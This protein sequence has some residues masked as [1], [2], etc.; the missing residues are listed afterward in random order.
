[1]DCFGQELSQLSFTNEELAKCR[2]WLKA[3]SLA[4]NLIV[5]L[6]DVKGVG[7]H[8][9][10][11]LQKEGFSCQY[12]PAILT[13]RERRHSVHHDK[14][15][16]L[17]A[18][19]VGKVILTKSEETLPVSAI[20]AQE[21]GYIRELDLLLQERQELVREQTAL[22]NQLHVL[23]HQY[24]GNTYRQ[25][26]KQ[27]FSEKALQWYQQDMDKGENKALGASISRR[28]K[29]LIL[30]ASQI[31][32]ITKTINVTDK[33]IPEVS[34]LKEKLIGC[35]TL[36]AAKIIVEIGTIMRFRSKATLAKYAGIA[37]VKNQSSNTN[38]LYTNTGGNRKL[39]QAIHT[40]A[41]SQIGGSGHEDAK[42]Y[43]Q[44]KLKEGKSKLWAI[45]CL[46][47]HICNK[48]FVLLKNESDKQRV[49]N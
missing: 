25:T 38:R 32:D 30:T 15:D 2:D 27:I 41:L 3:L 13:Q 46:K 5:G 22:K 7:I 10:A 36:T 11:Y 24:Y 34:A 20:V 8:L 33:T 19:R 26:F 31:T 28:I 21:P 44:K 47:R 42:Q 17:D 43:Y 29:R 18:K 39:N 48:V 40:I 4:D 14:S 37:P 12:V 9:C 1:M 6:E 49:T 35:G 45:R 16:Y 23:L